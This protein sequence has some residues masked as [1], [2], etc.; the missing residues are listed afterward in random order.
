VARVAKP[1]LVQVEDAFVV[2][3]TKGEW[4]S[5]MTVTDLTGRLGKPFNAKVATVLDREGFWDEMVKAVA[6][7]GQ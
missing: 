3:E 4:T 5:G 1:D 7:L 2:V 6:A